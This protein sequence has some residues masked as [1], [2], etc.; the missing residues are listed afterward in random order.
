[1]YL[2]QQVR[3]MEAPSWNWQ[4]SEAACVLVPDTTAHRQRSCGVHASMVAEGGPTQMAFM[5]RLIW[6]W[7][8]SVGS[9]QSISS[10]S[11]VLVLLLLNIG[12]F[13][14]FWLTP[15]YLFICTLPQLKNGWTMYEPMY[16]YL[17]LKSDLVSWHK[18]LLHIQKDCLQKDNKAD[19]YFTK[20]WHLHSNAALHFPNVLE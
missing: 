1:M 16:P 12:S 19:F 6:M 9:V 13:D 2:N 3:S 14:F 8:T 18:N 11:W 15:F 20:E 4:G 5:S 10:T 7:S 17:Y